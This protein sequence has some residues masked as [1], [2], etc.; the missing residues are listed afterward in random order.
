MS[1]AKQAPSI[2]DGLETNPRGKGDQA[3]KEQAD[4]LIREVVSDPR[5]GRYRQRDVAL[6]IRE[7]AGLPHIGSPNHWLRSRIASM[8]LKWGGA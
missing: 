1:K 6:R 2:L 5:H 3:A 4:A 8:G 7:R